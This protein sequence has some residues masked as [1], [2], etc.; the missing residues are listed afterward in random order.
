[1]TFKNL[2]GDRRLVE[3]LLPLVLAILTVYFFIRWVTLDQA[4]YLGAFLIALLS[5]VILF[6][7]S[8]SRAPQIARRVTSYIIG[9][10]SVTFFLTGYFFHRYNHTLVHDNDLSHNLR[11][12]EAKVEYVNEYFRLR[13]KWIQSFI[14]RL[15]IADRKQYRN[16]L[17]GFYTN[18]ADHFQSLY[19]L[20][21]DGLSQYGAPQNINYLEKASLANVTRPTFLDPALSFSM[22]GQVRTQL[23]AVKL[24]VPFFSPDSTHY[25]L[26]VVVKL[27]DL[28]D[29][30]SRIDKKMAFHLVN[31]GESLASNFPDV[32]AREIRDYPD[33][34]YVEIEE[35][36]T[37][38]TRYA[39][40]SISWQVATL[41]SWDQAFPSVA[42][43][44]RELTKMLLLA[45]V[46][47]IVAGLVL[48][49]YLTK[50]ILSPVSTLHRDTKAIADGDLDRAIDLPSAHV[51]DEIAGLSH[52]VKQ[53]VGSLKDKMSQL[54][55]LNQRLAAAQ[56]E[57]DAQLEAAGRIQRG[58]L[59]KD[60]LLTAGY[61]IAGKL[62]LLH[63]VGGDYYDYF[64]IDDHRVG[65]IIIDAAGKG[66]AA[67]FYASLIKGIT[68][69]QLRFG[70]FG[71][72]P[73]SVFFTSVEEQ[74]LAIRDHRTRTVAMQFAVVD[75][76][77][78]HVHLI[79]AGIDNPILVRNKAIEVF[80]IP[81]RAMGMPSWLGAFQEVEFDL[82]AG[83]LLVLHTDGV[84]NLEESLL[85]QKFQER[86]W[87]G[88]G[89]GDILEEVGK[90]SI[91]PQSLADDVALV[92]I[93]LQPAERQFT[94]ISSIPDAE[95]P[96]VDHIVKKMQTYE[97][98]ENQINDFRIALREALVNAIKHGNQYDADAYV[99][100]LIYGYRKFLEVKIQD[101]G[102][103]FEPSK[104]ESPDIGKKIAGQQRTG[105]WG[106]HVIQKLVSDWSLHRTDQGTVLCLR[107]IG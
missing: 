67:S 88:H 41:Q 31:N 38:I 84:P 71:R 12:V 3:F 89:V 47:G 81:G 5:L 9:A 91:A 70:E 16:D 96:M 68:E 20:N 25:F 26:S 53:M 82:E 65:V 4:F 59:P 107:M 23:T 56:S 79:N 6:I 83:D 27:E 101:R 100:I 97:F 22:E 28:D 48:A 85:T 21:K 14:E 1:M 24:I 51:S 102:Q 30:I 7:L 60:P 2:A 75:T 46:I 98:S 99:N 69:F 103:G 18:H 10:L 63:K 15:V 64:E 45:G 40:T 39:L 73:L 43:T 86:E 35:T 13:T 37:F 36:R 42:A 58:F 49:G 94:K 66:I 93:R 32:G 17:N 8:Y 74:I 106:F 54:G 72:V 104:L 11:V 87:G 55:Q 76:L 95:I 44:D 33:V 29:W 57:I 61:E 92:G 80:D 62:H 90:I 78:G 34:G 105:G 77:T 19:I 50:S 52:A